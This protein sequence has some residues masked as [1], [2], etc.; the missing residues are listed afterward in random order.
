MFIIP[1]WTLIQF[2]AQNVS[3]TV[4]RSTNQLGDNHLELD[5]RYHSGCIIFHHPSIMNQ[6]V[7]YLLED[8]SS[9]NCTQGIG[10]GGGGRTGE[11]RGRRNRVG[12]NRG[13]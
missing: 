3:K 12:L 8:Q 13:R 10:G 1:I 11:R 2:M 7:Q 5:S 6:D 9:N 4:V